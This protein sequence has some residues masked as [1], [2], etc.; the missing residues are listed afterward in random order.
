[1]SDVLSNLVQVALK[2]G[3]RVLNVAAISE[4]HAKNTIKSISYGDGATNLLIY[5]IE[6]VNS[7]HFQD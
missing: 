7:Q 3:L 2:A 1:M 4:C 5:D 6:T